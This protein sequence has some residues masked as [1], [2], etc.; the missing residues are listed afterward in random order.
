MLPNPESALEALRRDIEPGEWR[1]RHGS[2]STFRILCFPVLLA[3]A[4][5][6]ETAPFLVLFG[7][8]LLSDLLDGVLARGL[9]LESDFG[10]RLDQWGD[11]ALWLSFAVGAIWLWPEIVRREAPY[12]VLAI[13]CLLLPTAIAYAKYRS[14][15]GY[16]T[17]LAKLT[18]ILMGVAVPL[19]LIFDFAWPFR[20]AAFSLLLSGV[21]EIAITWLLPECRHDVPSVLHALRLRSRSD[22]SACQLSP[23]HCEK[24]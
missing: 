23:P 16:H 21:D 11:F 8:G 6:G 24:L 9:G 15:P 13:T 22:S 18:S 2:L 20:V 10:A 19:L 1:L 4:W 3:L 14:V 5:N 7:I 12:A 17:W